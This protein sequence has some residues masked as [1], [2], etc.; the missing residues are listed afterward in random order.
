M[1]ESGESSSAHV[2]DDF[3]LT[4]TQTELLGLLRTL[5]NLINEVIDMQ[6]LP[7]VRGRLPVGV[8]NAI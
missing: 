7:E 3:Q 5:V 2:P 4:H 8:G 6:K 1:M